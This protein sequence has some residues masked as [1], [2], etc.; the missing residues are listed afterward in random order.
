MLTPEKVDRLRAIMERRHQEIVTLWVEEM[1]RRSEY[2]DRPDDELHKS[3][4]QGLDSLIALICQGDSDPVNRFVMKVAEWRSQLGFPLSAIT[5]A[6]EGFRT[7]MTRLLFE[8]IEGDERLEYLGAIFEGINYCQSELSDCY[9]TIARAKIQANVDKLEE[10]VAK[11]G[12]AKAE[13]RRSKKTQEHFLDNISHELR[14]PL[15]IIQGFAQL[16]VM[17]R[18]PPDETIR[19]A[20][21]IH[22][23]GDVLMRMISD[24]LLM[25]KIQGD[26]VAPGSAYIFI[27]DLATQV[28]E[29][30]KGNGG[31][32]RNWNVTLDRS[33]PL[34]IGDAEMLQRMFG[35]L[36]DNALKF[37]PDG[38]AIDIESKQS[39]PFAQLIV[40]DQ[41]VGLH[42]EDLELIF[43]PFR[44]KD[45][46]STR[47]FS[48]AGMGLT[49][50]R[51]VARLHGGDITAA[52]RIDGPGALFTL[53]L[54]RT[55]PPAQ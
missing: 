22:E 36:V 9:Q 44:Q 4:S 6:I 50:A 1:K 16:L 55:N 31:N 42:Q 46:A 20:E 10:T 12:A 17:G 24:L 21:K 7:V 40:A 43:D 29:T 35:H 32:G 51:M 25:S 45:G 47:V 37:S 33:S 27:N 14:T 30:A 52:C 39:G 2:A 28:V 34:V 3:I 8:E 11:L 26:S 49:L 53:S 15:T 41:G 5:F 48:G 23:A 38:S 18:V 19:L 13:A 54:P